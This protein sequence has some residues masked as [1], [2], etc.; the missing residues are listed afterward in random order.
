MERRAAEFTV[1]FVFEKVVQLTWRGMPEKTVPRV[2]DLALLGTR[3]NYAES[4][5]A[6]VPGGNCW[7]P[8]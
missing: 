4:M 5:V 3:F 7:H 1:R 6:R 8:V 2:T